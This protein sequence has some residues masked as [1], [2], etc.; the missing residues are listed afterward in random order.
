[1]MGRIEHDA[2]RAPEEEL[3][4]WAFAAANRAKVAVHD[5]SGRATTY[6]ELLDQVNRLSNAL[7]AEGVEP[8]DRLAFL[9]GN[10]LEIHVVTLACAQSGVLFVPLN[11][12]LDVDDLSHVLTDSGASILISD[13]RFAGAAIAAAEAA[14]LA[15]R[16]RFSIGEIS[17]FRDL[18]STVSG[19]SPELPTRR[20][21]GAPLF[22]TSGTTGRP[23]GVLRRSMLGELAAGLEFSLRPE[24]VH[25]WTDETVYLAQ[26]PLYHVGPLSNATTVL[27]L[28]GTVVHMDKWDAETCLS[29]IERHGVTASNMVPTMFYRLLALPEE[30]RTRYDVSSLRPDHVVHGA[31]ICPVHVKQA[32]IDWWGPVFWETYGA[33]EAAFT[34]VT[35]KDWLTRPGT[36]GR[37]RAGVELLIVDDDGNVCPP[38]VVGTIYGRDFDRPHFG[39]EY[40]NSPDKTAGSRRGDWFTVGDLGHLDDDGWL[41]MSDRRLDLVISGGVNIY[42]AEIEAVLVQHP[43]VVDVVVFGTPNAEWGQDVTA[44]V[45][46]R[47]PRTNPALVADI[48]RF[49]AERLPRFKQPRRVFLEEAMPR[50]SFGKINRRLLRDMY[51]GGEAGQP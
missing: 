38:N 40:Y 15:P 27:H 34:N 18:G 20:S 51:A 19:A 41:F 33:T 22:Y 28:G 32:M 43:E 36:V 12:H 9:F 35:S 44:V 49:A 17:G 11:H 10:Q 24:H 14:A 1:M 31:A 13:S 45:E 30:V 50:F 23:K 16:A 25:G 21:A 48:E 47:H 46:A 42:P 39:V 26:G 2:N 6:G 7:V 37:A 8:G 5:A 29:L 4:F 3:G